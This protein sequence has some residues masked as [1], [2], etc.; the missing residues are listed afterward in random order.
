[1][2][3]IIL[4]LLVSIVSLQAKSSVDACVPIGKIVILK[5][6][7]MSLDLS[8]DQKDKLLKYEEK[9][10][11]ELSKIKDGAYDKKER[12]SDLFS[13]KEFLRKKFIDIATQ[14]NIVL[15]DAIAEYFENMYK[16]LNSEQREKLIKKF[17]RIEKKRNE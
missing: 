16:A 8:K 17:K 15:M 5:K 3:K 10:K 6:S 13:E 1:M 9:L 4:I 11:D 2:V 7:I 14:E 12:L